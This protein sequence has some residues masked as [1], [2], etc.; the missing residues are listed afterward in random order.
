M[1]KRRFEVTFSMYGEDVDGGVIELDDQVIDVVD[2]EWRANLYDLRTPEQIAEHIAF[3]MIINNR[4]LSQLD[5][6]ADQ[7]DSNA[8]ILSHPDLDH[9]EMDARE[10]TNNS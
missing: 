2:D 10:I 1:A 5:G 6:W 7:P 4:G 8:K 9:W 3:N